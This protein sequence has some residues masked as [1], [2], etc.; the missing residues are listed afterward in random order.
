LVEQILQQPLLRLTYRGT[1]FLT[2]SSASGSYEHSNSRSASNSSSLD[3]SN[4]ANYYPALLLET[5]WVV[6]ADPEGNEFCAFTD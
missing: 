4:W 3:G 1:N 6:L 2:H 5:G